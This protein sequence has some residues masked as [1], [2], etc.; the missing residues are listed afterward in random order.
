MDNQYQISGN[1]VILKVKKASVVIR[2][3]L[4]FFSALAIALPLGGMIANFSIDPSTISIMQVILF[5]ILLFVSLFVFRLGLWNTFGQ[6]EFYF[7]EDAI[8]YQANYG[9]FKDKQKKYSIDAKKVSLNYQVIGFEED[10]KGVMLIQIG[11][12]K[13]GSAVKMPIEE[14]EQICQVLNAKYAC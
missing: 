10:K 8:S 4:F 11:E 9:W 12:K 5:F 3:C 1:Q 14:I 6:E 2:F 13:V 7:G